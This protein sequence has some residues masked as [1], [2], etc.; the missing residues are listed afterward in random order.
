MI[1]VIPTEFNIYDILMNKHIFIMNVD[2]FLLEYLVGINYDSIF[3]LQ[4]I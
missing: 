3:A 2:N 1:L 4:Q